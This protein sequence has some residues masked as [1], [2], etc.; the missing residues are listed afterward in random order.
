MRRKPSAG[1]VDAD[2]ARRV[3]EIVLGGVEQRPSGEKT[4]WPKK[5]LPAHAGDGLGADGR[6]VEDR[7]EGAGLAGEHHR[8]PRD[9]IEGYVVAAVRQVD[10]VQI[11]PF[12]RQDAA[13]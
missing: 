11:A 1:V 6:M 13:P 5:C 10:L 9:R 7:G 4:P 8:P 3:V 12:L 2:H